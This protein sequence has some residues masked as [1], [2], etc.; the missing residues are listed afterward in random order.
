MGTTVAGLLFYNDATA[1][2]VFHIGDS[3]VYRVRENKLEQLT[4]DHSAYQQWLDNGSE[5]E[6]P[7][8]NLILRAGKPGKREAVGKIQT[9]DH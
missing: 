5:S 4:R 2:L 9:V 7:S 8:H 3:R 6:S 1:A